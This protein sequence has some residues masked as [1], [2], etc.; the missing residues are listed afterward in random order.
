MLTAPEAR[1]IR[2]PAGVKRAPPSL[3]GSELRR[4]REAAGIPLSQFARSLGVSAAYLS[5]VELGN[6]QPFDAE[7]IGQVA[8]LLDVNASDLK[9][10]AAETRGAFILEP[11][12][13]A[14]QRTG[15]ALMRRWHELDEN[16][17][18]LIAQVVGD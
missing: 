1:R 9:V 15:R 12:T 2:L 11:V 3:F 13:A 4:I 10:L 6:R 17:L 14:H 7:R 8:R 16:A 5:D 18:A